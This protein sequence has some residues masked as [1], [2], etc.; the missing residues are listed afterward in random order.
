MAEKDNR[1]KSEQ[2]IIHDNDAMFAG[3]SNIDNFLDGLSTEQLER[4]AESFEPITLL[5]IDPFV[6]NK[7]MQ[8]VLGL[9]ILAADASSSFSQILELKDKEIWLSGFYIDGHSQLSLKVYPLAHYGSQMFDVTA[10]NIELVAD[11]GTKTKKLLEDG[12][13]TFLGLAPRQRYTIVQGG[14]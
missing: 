3:L 5:T 8:N 11:D 2:P 12:Y 6:E 10:L 9:K 1:P 7:I 14:S 4:L 13:I